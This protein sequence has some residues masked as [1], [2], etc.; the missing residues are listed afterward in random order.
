[1]PTIQQIIQSNKIESIYALVYTPNRQRSR[2]RFPENCVFKMDGEQE[3]KTAANPNKNLYPA[4][5]CGPSKSSEGY[6]LYYLIEWL[7]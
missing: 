4:L 2:H 7:D 6:M 5:I 3:A 1:M